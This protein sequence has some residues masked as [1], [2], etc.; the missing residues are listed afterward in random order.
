MGL[1]IK[2]YFIKIYNIE[3]LIIHININLEICIQ[4]NILRLL[5]FFIVILVKAQVLDRY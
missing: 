5:D 1:K 3:P 2:M 4:S